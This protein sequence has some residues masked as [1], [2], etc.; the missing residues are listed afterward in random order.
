MD[1]YYH[2]PRLKG[3]RHVSVREEADEPDPVRRSPRNGAVIPLIQAI[4]KAFIL[5][6]DAASAA[7]VGALG[8]AQC[9][10]QEY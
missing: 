8:E 6:A 5:P 10:Q 4:A 2:D 7:I 3:N 1:A 9:H